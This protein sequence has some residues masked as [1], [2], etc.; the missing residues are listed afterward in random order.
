MES[1]K[2]IGVFDSGMGGLSVLKP[3]LKKFKSVDF[4]YFGDNK[5][6]PYGDKSE[7]YILNRMEFVFDFLLKQNCD[8]VIIACNTA[9]VVFLNNQARFEN[10][11]KVFKN[12]IIEIVT[13]TLNFIKENVD[14]NSNVYILATDKTVSSHFYSKNLKQF[15]KSIKEISCQEI[16]KVIET[17][18]FKNLEN[19]ILNCLKNVDGCCC[20]D[21][22]IL[23]CTH[24]PLVLDVFKKFT[25][26]ETQII[27][28]GEIVLNFLERLIERNDVEINLELNPDLP[29]RLCRSVEFFTSSEDENVLKNMMIWLNKA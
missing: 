13:P 27:T 23:G 7:E 9:S 28:Q 24:F 20:N 29:N 17:N 14:S 6:S 10:F 18:D 5:F 2:K 8:L 4:V 25:K 19:S 12:R 21:Y 26:T 22:I 1:V 11:K 3:L 16:V 15:V